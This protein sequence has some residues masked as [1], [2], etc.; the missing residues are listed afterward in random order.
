MAK[1]RSYE[2][3][4]ASGNGQSSGRKSDLKAREIDVRADSLEE[5]ESDSDLDI[6]AL[7]RKY[8]PEYDREAEEE[9]ENSLISALD[10][11]FSSTGSVDKVD[12]P[13]VQQELD[14]YEFTDDIPRVPE[15][16]GGLEDA[17]GI[18]EDDGEYAEP[19]AEHKKKRGGLF[20]LGSRLRPSKKRDAMEA[21]VMEEEGWSMPDDSDEDPLLSMGAEE[22][23]AEEESVVLSA[24]ALLRN[25]RSTRRIAEDP[26][27]AAADG[28]DFRIDSLFSEGT[29]EALPAAEPEAN[30]EPEPEA[31]DWDLAEMEDYRQDGNGE[32]EEFD[33]TDINLMVAFGMDDESNRKKVGKRAHMLGDQLEADMAAQESKKIKL[34]RPEYV[35]R[36]QNKEIDRTYQRTA[37]G[38]WIKLGLCSLF[39][40]LL[41]VFE[42]IDVLAKL[43]TGTA[44]Q[45]GGVFDPAVYPVVYTM[46][47]LQLMLL[48]CLCAYE[49]IYRG[50]L[51]LFR[52]TPR[53]ESMTALLAVAGI[54]YSAVIAQ[55]TVQ[56]SEPVM[57]NFVVAV[58]ALMTL[59]GD[60]FNTRREMLNFRVVSSA[61]PKH[62]VCRVSDEQSRGET[63]AFADVDDICDV[64]KIEKTDFIEGFYT[65]L[66]IPDGTTGLFMSCAM[67]VMAAAAILFGLFTSVRGG[68]GV[69]IARVIC[70][71]MM[72]VAPLSVYLSL[73]YPFYRANAAA[74]EYDS[75]IVGEASLAEYSNA[76]IVTFE[77]KNVFPSYGV[78]VQNIRIHNN[79]R[80]DRVMYYAASVFSKAGGPLQDVFEI[81]TLEMGHSD[82]V[83]IHETESGF[84]AAEVDGVNITFGSGEVLQKKGLT[85]SRNELEDDVDFSEELSI[86]YMF[87]EEKLVAKMY[88]QYVMDAD[89]EVILGQFQN[90]GLYGCVR[91]F[92]PNID[93]RM[94]ARK[95]RM[96][97]MPLK[98][99]RYTDIA[100][101]D[102][103]KAK[104]DSGL[105]TSGTPKSLLQIISYCDKLLHTKKTNLALAI[106]A[107]LIGTAIMALVV[108]SGSIGVVH[109][110]YIIIYQLLWLIPILVSSRMFIR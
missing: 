81:A 23:G 103:Y 16:D 13:S 37:R 75:T 15:D 51:Y 4:S 26:A 66:A 22:D 56:A 10:S 93:E 21:A 27:P 46:V 73:S 50:I 35:D 53:P 55:I 107:I 39:T 20:S 52:G 2:R 62:I 83:V 49:Q 77:D 88:I 24:S 28:E 98:V 82:N 25:R 58:S 87:R 5:T 57:F 1:D 86:M 29:E 6:N 78:K 7:L 31:D 12:A 42:N 68:T 59:V 85:I 108:L 48:A 33:P 64:M 91:T 104:A 9:N 92:D 63:T 80:I 76:S 89:I 45:F 84:L 36:S 19:A 40:V 106:L 101:V 54:I 67:A 70:V 71:S 102:A 100:E 43:F 38:L 74:G 65:R 30:A 44:K 90:S 17:E 61:K 94:I 110:L 72:T 109:S 47:S 32:T 8:M 99:V 79:A 41:M 96:K 60:I 95:V 14:E 105:V 34:D 3:E 11:A 97:R 18:Y 69:E